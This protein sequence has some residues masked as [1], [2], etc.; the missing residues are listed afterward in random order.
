MTKSTEHFEFLCEKLDDVKGK[1]IRENLVIDKVCTIIGKIVLNIDGERT[2]SGTET[3][4]P[5]K[6]QN[7]EQL[8][9]IESCGGKELLAAFLDHPRGD[10][11]ADSISAVEGM[12]LCV[13]RGGHIPLTFVHE[14]KWKRKGDTI[15]KI[16]RVLDSCTVD[17]EINE[18]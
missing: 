18:V 17:R 7:R 2:K 13:M 8:W 6:K 16:V 1:N 4:E 11:R 9:I 14:A 15:T 12:G 5:E 10:V 3:T